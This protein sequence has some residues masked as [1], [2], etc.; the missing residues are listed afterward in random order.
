MR[1]MNRTLRAASLTFAAAALVL[2]L[3]AGTVQADPKDFVVEPIDPQNWKNQYDLTWDDWADIP[4]TEWNDPDVKPS[5]RGLRIALVA[6]DFKDIPFVITQP[7]GSDPFGN[8]QIDPIAREDVPQFYRDYYMEPNEYNHGRTIHEYWME[9]SRGRL[10]VD[11]MDTFGSYQLPRNQFEYGL[12]EGWIRDAPGE[13]CPEGYTCNGNVEGDADALWKADLAAR[14]IPCPNSRCGYDVVL[15]VYAGYD[16]T[17]VWQE[18]GEMMFQTKEDVPDEWGP[19]EWLDPDDSMPNWAPTRYVEW[20]SWLASSQRWGSASIRQAESS[21]TITHEMGHFFFSI[22]DNNNNPFSDRQNP[23]QPFHR[24]GSAP[25]DMMDRGSFNGP[26]GHHMRWVVPPNMGGWSPSGLMVRNK[27]HAGILPPENVLDVS[28][29]ALATTGLVVGEV[30]ARAVDP[31]AEGTSGV[32][33]RL[34][35][36]GPVPDRTPFCNYDADPFCHTDP[37]DIDNRPDVVNNQ[38]GWDNYT[39]EVVDRMGFD[40]FNPDTG[41]IIAK[42][43]TSE[44]PARNTC[45]YNCFNWVIDANPQDI[46]LVDFYKPDGTP[47]MATIADHR[48]LNDAAFHAGL[49]SGSEYEYVDEANRL[50]FYVIDTERDDEGV[51]SYTLAVRSLD[52]DGAQERGVEVGEAEVMGLRTSQAAQCTFPLT[53]T[54]E[55]AATTTGHPADVA[56]QLDNDVYRLTAESSAQGWT[57][58]LDNALTTARAGDTVEVPV[59]VTRETPAAR[60]TTV[61]LTATSES[62]PSATRSVTCTVAVQD[63]NPRR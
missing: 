30:T 53:N 56:D 48:Q 7:K 25:W 13:H 5:E 62:D 63:T 1:P 29:E 33:V 46:G 54:G 15:R 16:Q 41:V 22:G 10:G 2:G 59:Y 6:V 52:G 3:S 24:V 36:P 40:S 49:D 55:E 27:I 51:L 19:P 35:G 32:K 8:P 28:R 44:G 31:G 12:N 20:T 45:G 39:L 4:G 58:Q 47:V 26:G 17:S 61:M 34:D 11:E 57:A 21:G 14:G 18:F 43:K 23:P 9:Q 38:T 37:V 60:E 50:H 42:N